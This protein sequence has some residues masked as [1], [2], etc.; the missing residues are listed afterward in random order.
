MG[1]GLKFW[2]KIFHHFESKPTYELDD[3]I[4]SKKHGHEIC[5]MRLVGKNIFPLMTTGGI[6]SSRAAMAGLSN[7]DL[8]K[9]TRL[10]ME[11]RYKKNTLRLIETDRNG[12][13]LFE[14]QF[15][16]E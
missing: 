2:N 16:K 7:E 6:L 1:A 8:V 10:D 3:I 5:V 11:I 9:I 13:A 14:D 4:Y 15:K 12:T